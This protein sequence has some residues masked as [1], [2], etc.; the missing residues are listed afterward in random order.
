MVNDLLHSGDLFLMSKTME[1]LKEQFWNWEDALKS[2][3]LK[4]SIG[5]TKVMVSGS[6][7]S[8]PR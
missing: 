8:K 3:G 5:K 4:V 6:N 1:D 7:C 2:M